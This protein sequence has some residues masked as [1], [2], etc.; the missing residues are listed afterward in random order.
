MEKV[1]AIVVGRS[2]RPLF[3]VANVMC[4]TQI[5][6]D[7]MIA[8]AKRGRYAHIIWSGATRCWLAVLRYALL[9]SPRAT[10]FTYGGI[11]VKAR[12]CNPVM[13]VCVYVYVCHARIYPGQ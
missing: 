5:D 6:S 9:V 8:S 2:G 13:C 4:S 7:S 10:R 1:V 11:A 3:V 12:F